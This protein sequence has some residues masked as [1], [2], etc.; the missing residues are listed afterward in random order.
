MN[1][2][3]LD[4]FEIPGGIE[5][6]VVF[7]SHRDLAAGVGGLEIPDDSFQVHPFANLR[8]VFKTVEDD[9]SIRGFDDF[10]GEWIEAARSPPLNVPLVSSFNAVP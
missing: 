9:A 1:A 2:I 10:D 6:A 3:A 5:E 4:R 8:L 7:Q